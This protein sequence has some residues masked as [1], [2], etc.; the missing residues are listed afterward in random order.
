MFDSAGFHQYLVSGYLI[1]SVLVLLLFS[2]LGKCFLDAFDDESRMDSLLK[3][4]VTAR[5]WADFAVLLILFAV[6]LFLIGYHLVNGF[7]WGITTTFFLISG[8]LP[9]LS[10]LAIRNFFENQ[11]RGFDYDAMRKFSGTI[12][13]IEFFQP[14]KNRSVAITLQERNDE[15]RFQCDYIDTPEDKKHLVIGSRIRVYYYGNDPDLFIRRVL[16]EPWGDALE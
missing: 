13:K 11:N 16:P 12:T 8:T 4:A 3:R 15:K 9:L 6:F 14:E 2:F 7:H 10:R 5:Y 1:M